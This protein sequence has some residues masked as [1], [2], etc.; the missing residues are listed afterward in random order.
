MPFVSSRDSSFLAL[1]L[2]PH[3]DDGGCFCYPYQAVVLVSIPSN[4]SKAKKKLIGVITGA[5]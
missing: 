2:L 4:P 3:S 1:N 5:I